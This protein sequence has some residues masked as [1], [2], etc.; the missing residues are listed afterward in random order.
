MAL[1]ITSKDQ[2]IDLSKKEIYLNQDKFFSEAIDCLTSAKEKCSE[3]VF[4]TN[5]GSTFPSQIEDICLHLEEV[6]TK[7]LKLYEGIKQDNETIYRQQWEEY[8]EYKN[9]LKNKAKDELFIAR[10]K[11]VEL[12]QR[13]HYTPIEN[14]AFIEQEL[15]M[16]VQ[17]FNE[18]NEINSK[19]IKEYFQ[20]KDD[21]QQ[22]FLA[23]QTKGAS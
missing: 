16:A 8:V 7:I 9:S 1:R 6:N 21:M 19:A 22:A 2:I 15:Q 23:L 20:A 10:R 12:E 13:L 14:R 18:L 3:K 17:N 4:A 5:L 11:I